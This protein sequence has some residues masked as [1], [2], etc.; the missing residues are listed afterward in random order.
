M[1]FSSKTSTSAWRKWVYDRIKNLSVGGSG[2][3]GAA[4]G[5][6]FMHMGA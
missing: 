1:I 3:G 6:I 2:G 5:D 4:A